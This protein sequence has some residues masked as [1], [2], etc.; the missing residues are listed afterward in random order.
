VR[1]IRLLL[2]AAVL[3]APAGCGGDG[4][5][6]A[7]ERADRPVKPPAGWRTVTNGPAGFTIAAPTTWTARTKQDATL[8]RSEDRLVVITIAADRSRAGRDTAAAEY[9][10]AALQQLPGFEGSVSPRRQTIKGSPYQTARVDG[11]GSVQTSERPQ[12]ITVVAYHRP[13]QVT[14]AAVVFR[15]AGVRPRFNDPIINRILPTFRARPPDET[16]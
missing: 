3:A 16:S 1:S 6:P 10:R 14:Y 13:D 15:N 9:A 11:G 5:G 4:S 7:E 8:I 2:A 12:R